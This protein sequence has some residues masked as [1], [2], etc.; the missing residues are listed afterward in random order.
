MIEVQLLRAT[1]MK[2]DSQQDAAKYFDPEQ[3]QQEIHTPP[4][5]KEETGKQRKEC[6]DKNERLVKG[7]D[8]MHAA[9]CGQ[10]LCQPTIL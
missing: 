3:G 6:G 9:L 5:K 10:R 4:I 7:N 1:E 8:W 2:N